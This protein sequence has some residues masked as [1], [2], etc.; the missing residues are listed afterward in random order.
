[1]PPLLP[2][3]LPGLACP[4]RSAAAL[5][6]VLAASWSGP[7]QAPEPAPVP[8]GPSAAQR[9]SAAVEAAARDE[10]RLERVELGVLRADPLARLGRRVAFVLQ[11]DHVQERFDPWLSRFGPADW[12]AVSAWPDEAFVWEPEVF[13][14]PAPRLF[15]RRGTR[16]AAWLR[17]GERYR[18]FEAIGIVREVFLGEPWIE[19][20]GV[21]PLPDKV[22]EGAILHVGRAQAFLAE[23]SF[24]LAEEQLLRAL[25]APLPTHAAS[26][27]ER[28][29]AVVREAAAVTREG[30]KS[31]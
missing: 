24:A 6:L 3:V 5:A 9:A 29:R 10:L 27:I 12:L 1:M 7:G 23:G 16:A 31:R 18:R 28:L 21:R 17:P 22:V 25:D 26:E 30:R 15:V 11:L 20:E 8:G 19:L 2:L 13:A 14:D 4:A